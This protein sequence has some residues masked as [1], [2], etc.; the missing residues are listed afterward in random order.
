MS[1]KCDLFGDGGGIRRHQDE[2]NVFNW[3]MPNTTLVTKFN[4]YISIFNNILYEI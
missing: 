2:N 3:V 1:P 4:I